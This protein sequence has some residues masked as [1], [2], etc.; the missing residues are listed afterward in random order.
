[1]VVV[2]PPERV[3]ELARRAWLPGGVA[4]VVA[5]GAR[6]QDVGGRRRPAPG[7]ARRTARAPARAR[8]SSSTTARDRSSP[9]ALVEAVADGRR[10]ARRGDAGAARRR[11]AQAG[12][13]TGGRRDTVDRAGAGRR[14]DAP[15]RPARACSWTRGR[16]SRPTARRRSPTRPRCWRPVQSPSM[17]SPAT[18][19]P[20]G[21]RCPT[22]SRRVETRARRRLGAASGFGID[23][24]AF[25]PGHGPA[26]GRDRGAGR[27]PAA[28]PLRRRRGAPR[29]GRRAAGGRGAGRPRAAVPGRRPDAARHRQRASCS[30]EVDGAAR[31]GGL[32]PVAVDVTV[33]G[34]RP[35]L[36]ARLD[37]M[38][39]AI[40]ALLGLEPDAVNVKASTGNLLRRRGRRPRRSRRGPSP[41]SRPIA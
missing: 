23:S 27:A 12:R 33:I 5:G 37:A 6:R 8:R 18:R 34:A 3:A 20:Q 11:D 29:G 1:M 31:G 9:P 35:R 2:T 26:T 40:A 41:P 10:G 36:G 39:D 17:R 7:R 28:R 30:A 24:H 21:D 14:A 15:G 4:A 16:R 25:G 13:A 19:E 22:I 38:R 32:A